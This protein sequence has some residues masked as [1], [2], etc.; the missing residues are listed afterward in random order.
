MLL[1]GFIVLEVTESDKIGLMET[2]ARTSRS[3]AKRKGKS[4]KQIEK[5]VFN[6]ACKRTALYRDYFDPDSD[7][8]KE[9]LGLKRAVGFASY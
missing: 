6:S 9:M 2:Q 4:S 8:E 3:N 1:I 5:Y 7:A